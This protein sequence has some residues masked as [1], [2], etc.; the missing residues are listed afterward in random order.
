M[1]IKI[2][3]ITNVTLAC[4][5]NQSN[6]VSGLYKWNDRWEP[7]IVNT[8]IYYR[9][10]KEFITALQ[11]YV[12]WHYIQSSGSSYHK[13]KHTNS[14]VKK[15]GNISIKIIIIIRVEFKVKLMV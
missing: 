14:K 11:H 10:K 6:C 7:K 2:S 3:N 5:D 9:Q 8:I 15:K 1:E 13:Q 4:D 12:S